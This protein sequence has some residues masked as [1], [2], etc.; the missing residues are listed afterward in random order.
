MGTA[1]RAARE[2]LILD[3]GTDGRQMTRAA[4]RRDPLLTVACGVGELLLTVGLVVLLYV[5][6]ELWVTDLLT[7]EEQG[8]IS[9]GLDRTWIAAPAYRAAPPAKGEAFTKLALPRVHSS[10]TVVEGISPDDLAKGPG[11]YPSSALPGRPGNVAVAGHRVT[12]GAPFADLDALHSCD[13]LIFETR[14]EWLVYRVLPFVDEVTGWAAGRGAEPRCRA[15]AP[16]GGPYA[17]VVGQ[18][19]VTPD[20]GD[21]VAPVPGALGVSPRLDQQ[22][23]LVTLTTCHPRF[24]ARQRLVVHGV[25]VARYPKDPAHPQWRPAELDET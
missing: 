14:G 11:H 10:F 24:S 7:A 15:V 12:H 16:L 2:S 17:G 25:L 13:A 6:Y 3:A 4:E 9:D 19:I 20:R 21:V 23:S 8:R 5:G 1:P 22:A 18:Q